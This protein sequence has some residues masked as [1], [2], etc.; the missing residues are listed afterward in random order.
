MGQLSS[1]GRT[2]PV[3][4]RL[5]RSRSGATAV[6][7]ALV[8]PLYF[9]ILCGI[10]EVG[11]MTWFTSSLNDGASQVG[12]FLREKEMNRQTPTESEIRTVACDAVKLSNLKCANLKI[13][14]YPA[15]PTSSTAV[16]EPKI[17]DNFTTPLNQRG[18]IIAFGY[19]WGFSFPSTKLLMVR[20]GD[21]VQVQSRIFVSVPERTIR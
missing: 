19:E 8:A 17:I 15:Y 12:N 7:F 18:Y 2:T 13:A 5:R 10:I 4:S 11:L 1:T 3:L 21:R 6:E 20:D 16:A 14:I 9:L